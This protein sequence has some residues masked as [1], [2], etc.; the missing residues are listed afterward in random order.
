MNISSEEWKN[1]NKEA[2]KYLAELYRLQEQNRVL[3][4]YIMN[5]N[6]R[7]AILNNALLHS[8]K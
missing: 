6:T 4:E 8:N 2:S 7:I 5:L 3:R 1:I